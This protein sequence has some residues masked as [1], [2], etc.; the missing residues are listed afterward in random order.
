MN[1]V[2]RKGF[3]CLISVLV[4]VV[5]WVFHVDRCHAYVED[6]G[7]WI[8]SIRCWERTVPG[9]RYCPKHGQL[10]SDD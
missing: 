7:G 3:D 9:Q 8:S 6:Y 2:A 5:R 10:T 4:S 1:G